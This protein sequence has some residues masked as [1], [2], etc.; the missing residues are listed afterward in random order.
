MPAGRAYVVTDPNIVAETQKLPKSFSLGPMRA[1]FTAQ[2]AGLSPPAA[3]K[4]NNTAEGNLLDEGLEMMREVVRPGIHLK[5]M[6]KVVATSLIR[7]LEKPPAQPQPLDLWEWVR[8]TITLAATDAAYG[9][10]NPFQD[11]AREQDFW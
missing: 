2:L 6:S 5:E 1:K 7:E 10:R 3:E 4:P 11:P 8:R 9:P